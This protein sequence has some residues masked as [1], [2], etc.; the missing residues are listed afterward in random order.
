MVEI[1]ENAVLADGTPAVSIAVATN[2]PAFARVLT[3][4]AQVVSAFGMHVE[5]QQLYTIV[6]RGTN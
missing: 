3:A 2:N 1:N 5:A 4:V 6:R